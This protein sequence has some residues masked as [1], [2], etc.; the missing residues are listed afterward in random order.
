M[1]ELRSFEE[2]LLKAGWVKVSDR[3]SLSDGRPALEFTPEAQHA[4]LLLARLRK[5]APIE[6]FVLNTL[7][8]Y[9]DHW[10]QNTN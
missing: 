6:G 5:E 2:A 9:A 4:L 10:Y 8:A 3:A 7:L 1:S